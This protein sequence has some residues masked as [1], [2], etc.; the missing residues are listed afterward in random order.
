MLLNYV[1]CVLEVLVDVVIQGVLEDKL[2]LKDTHVRT[3]SQIS[4]ILF[5]FFFFLLYELTILNVVVL[6]SLEAISC[7]E[8]WTRLD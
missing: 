4:S 1:N 7:P 5:F 2:K 8:R 3:Q 6:P